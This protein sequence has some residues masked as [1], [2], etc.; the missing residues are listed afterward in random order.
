MGGRLRR[1]LT[2]IDLTGGNP[3]DTTFTG[4]LGGSV[5]SDDAGANGFSFAGLNGT[6]PALLAPKR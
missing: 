3:A 6:T 4:V 5:G 1:Q 2:M